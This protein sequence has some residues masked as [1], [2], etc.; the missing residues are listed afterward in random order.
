MCNK[1]VDE[2]AAGLLELGMKP[3]DR[4]CLMGSNSVEWEITFLAS[5]KAGLITVI[6][7]F[8]YQKIFFKFAPN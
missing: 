1:Q 4:L 5:I 8:N 3:G 7:F 2:L 6:N